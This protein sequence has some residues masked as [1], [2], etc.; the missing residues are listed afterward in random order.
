MGPFTTQKKGEFL[1]DH[2]D[3]AVRGA[4]V[5]EEGKL[6]WPP[7]PLKVKTSTLISPESSICTSKQPHLHL[8][9]NPQKHQQSL[10]DHPTN[11]QKLY[12]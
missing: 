7:P 9:L 11:S 5:L 4:L 10:Q 8:K 2:E 3:E 12:E 1:I 6:M